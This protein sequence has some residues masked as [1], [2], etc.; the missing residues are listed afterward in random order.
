MKKD[1]DLSP[2]T[3]DELT[4]KLLADTN[5]K[6][7][8][9]IFIG[10]SRLNR[11]NNDLSDF[12]IY[13][14]VATD[15]LENNNYC[16]QAKVIYSNEKMS[17][18]NMDLHIMSLPAVYQRLCKGN[19]EILELFFEKPLWVD[20]NNPVFSE[21]ASQSNQI[22]LRSINPV[23][24]MHAVTGMTKN[25]LRE[26]E[27]HKYKNIKQL[28]KVNN[29]FRYF[30]LIMLDKLIKPEDLIALTNYHNKPFVKTLLEFS[31]SDLSVIDNDKQLTESLK[32]ADDT[33][34]LLKG[35]L[36]SLKELDISE[37]E[38]DKFFDCDTNKK[39]LH[40]KLLLALKQ[41]I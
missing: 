14:F 9:G 8:L 25:L 23:G 15:P 41:S 17:S 21:L 39:W 26:L 16:K 38:A 29:L 2:F 28:D 27:S 6:R 24:Y 34:G 30:Q 22:K 31:D 40:D 4:Q 10:G 35:N 13:I 19:P 7:P 20:K 36:V 33:K 18:I 11:V 5:V 12:D 37:G 3:R 32:E 1:L